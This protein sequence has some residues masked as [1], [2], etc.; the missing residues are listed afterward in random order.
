MYMIGFFRLSPKMDS[1]ATEWPCGEYWLTG[2]GR[3]LDG[4]VLESKNV[5]VGE[6]F[7]KFD[8]SKRC[9]GKL[10]DVRAKVEM[11]KRHEHYIRHPFRGA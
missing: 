4:H 8:F 2:S 11:V 1:L 7:E 6:E 3:M 5:L 10:D 9:D